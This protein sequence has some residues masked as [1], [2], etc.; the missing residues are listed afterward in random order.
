MS[1]KFQE[2]LRVP[3]SALD[4]LIDVIL[5]RFH[6]LDRKILINDDTDLFVMFFPGDG[7]TSFSCS[8]CSIQAIPI[9]LR[10]LG[11]PLL[12]IQ[13]SLAGMQQTPG[14]LPLY[15]SLR[16]VG[17]LSGFTSQKRIRIP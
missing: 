3:G 10:I 2:I 6:T 11:Q 12:T 17:H 9:G 7:V 1:V 13:H 15:E 16:M 14:S 8:I 4:Q 5:V